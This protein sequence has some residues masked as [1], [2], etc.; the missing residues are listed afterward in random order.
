M[1]TNSEERRSLVVA[2]AVARTSVWCWWKWRDFD[3][4]ARAHRFTQYLKHFIYF[5]FTLFQVHYFPTYTNFLQFP[6]PLPSAALA[7]FTLANSIRIW[8]IFSDLDTY[9]IL[10]Y[11]INHLL[12]LFWPTLENILITLM[13]CLPSGKQD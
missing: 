7:Q 13:N 8:P 5:H 12:F 9:P 11:I 3:I 1:F 2:V 10:I 6:L 4:R